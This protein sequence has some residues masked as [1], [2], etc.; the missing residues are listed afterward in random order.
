VIG[1]NLRRVKERIATA[2]EQ[3]G[4]QLSDITLVA[5]SKFHPPASVEAAIAAGQLDFGES[6]PQELWAKAGG[7]QVPSVR[8]HQIGNLQRNKIDR[9]IPIAT[10]IHSVNSVRLLDAIDRAGRKRGAVVPVLVEVNVSREAN[11]LGFAAE[12]TPMLV[13]HLRNL[14]GVKVEGLMTLAAYDAKPSECGAT[15]RELWKLRER[16]RAEWGSDLMLPHLSMG[17]SNDFEIAIKEGAT[18]VR[19]GSAIFGVRG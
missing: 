12:V 5:V 6:Y 3:S 10:L 13:K 14:E 7:I 8:W 4:R 18:I 17:M 15:F 9:T 2:A 1:D 19:I 11:K 16:L